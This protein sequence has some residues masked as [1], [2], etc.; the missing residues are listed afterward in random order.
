MENVKDVLGFFLYRGRAR[1]K[2]AVS[3]GV[4]T[5][6]KI[7][8]P[9]LGNRITTIIKK[10]KK[11]KPSGLFEPFLLWIEKSKY[12]KFSFR[13]RKNVKKSS[14]KSH[15]QSHKNKIC[16]IFE[17]DNKLCIPLFQKRHKEFEKI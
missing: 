16:N 11:I 17:L 13:A 9:S 1:E 8:E 12:Y 6:D 3:V 4:A 10:V 7:D 2:K 14:R 15:K 5:I